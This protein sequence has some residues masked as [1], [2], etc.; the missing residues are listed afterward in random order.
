[1]ISGIGQGSILGPLLFIAFVNGVS[2]IRLSD[3]AEIILYADDLVYVKPMDT[4]AAETE[5]A[6]DI[7]AIADFFHFYFSKFKCHQ[8]T[9][10]DLRCL[11]SRSKS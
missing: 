8:N 9:V 4:P 11:S 7:Q 3:G 5:L 1:M 6:R 2:E 10:Y